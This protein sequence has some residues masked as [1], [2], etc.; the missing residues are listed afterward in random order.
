MNG[1]EIPI[2]FNPDNADSQIAIYGFMPLSLCNIKMIIFNSIP[3]AIFDDIEEFK[4]E[5]TKHSQMY[6]YG[7]KFTSPYSANKILGML[8]HLK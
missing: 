4:G 7:N 6:L 1:V 2:Y 3:E 5:K 8:K